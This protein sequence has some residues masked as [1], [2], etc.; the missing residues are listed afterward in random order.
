MKDVLDYTLQEYLNQLLPNKDSLQQE[1]VQYAQEHHIPIVEDTV[2]NL[3]E[4]LIKLS[5]AS[6]VLEIGT[7]IGYSAVAI[8]KALPTDGHLTTIELM[9]ERREKAVEF[10][11]KARLE[12]KITSVLG[13]ARE[14]LQEFHGPYDMIFLDAAKGQYPIFFQYLANI[15]ITYIFY[16]FIIILLFMHFVN[17]YVDFCAY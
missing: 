11:A 4:M 3:L 5:K 16:Y 7:A 14:I 15:F 10:F 9:P 12:H 8:A 1:M 13:D 17:I 2:A 6:N